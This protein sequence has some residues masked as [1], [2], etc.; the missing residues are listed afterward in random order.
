MAFI[1][2]IAD[3]AF[4]VSFGGCTASE[5]RGKTTKME[6]KIDHSC[7]RRMKFEALCP[8]KPAGHRFCLPCA[9]RGEFG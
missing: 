6:M 4:A 1:D 7:S 9:R 3:C 5:G 2:R 8:D